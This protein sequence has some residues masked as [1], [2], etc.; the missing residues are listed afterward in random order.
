MFFG[1][2]LYTGNLM[3]FEL[4]LGT[5]IYITLMVAWML[6]GNV[7]A[8]EHDKNTY[9][10]LHNLPVSPLDI[11]WGKIGF[12]ICATTLVFIGTLLSCSIWLIAP[13]EADWENIKVMLLAFVPGIAE[14]WVWGILWSTRCRTTANALMGSAVCVLLVYYALFLTVT[15]LATLYG[16]QLFIM[17]PFRL[18]VV[19]IVGVF[20]LWGALRWFNFGNK[21]NRFAWFP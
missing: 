6:A 18:A 8:V 11:A 20:A 5:A 19:A 12:V 16:E 1:L 21:E 10:F 2:G 7:Y 9:G 15:P 3:P 13:L 14:A 4:Y 17:L